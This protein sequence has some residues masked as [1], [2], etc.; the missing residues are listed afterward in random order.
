[1]IDLPIPPGHLL[2]DDD[3]HRPEC[4]CETCEPYRPDLPEPLAEPRIGELMI[5][6]IL[7]GNAIA[8]AIDPHGAWAALADAFRSFAS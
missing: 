8:F 7:A 3:V 1:M 2:R 6:G 4:R 5:L